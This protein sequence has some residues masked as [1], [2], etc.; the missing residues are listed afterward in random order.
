MHELEKLSGGVLL[1]ELVEFL[2]R[3]GELGVLLGLLSLR[4][5]STD[6]LIAGIGLL[7]LRLGLRGFLGLVEIAESG[8]GVFVLLLL[9]FGLVLVFAVLALLVLGF[10]LGLIAFAIL[11]FGLGVTLLTLFA[12]FTVLAFVAIL[13]LIALITV[14][15]LVFVFFFVLLGFV[16]VFLF[17]IFGWLFLGIL[18]EFFEIG[19]EFRPV[20]DMGVES[21]TSIDAIEGIVNHPDGG[22]LLSG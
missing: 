8:F 18:E 22:F 2:Q 11:G 20:G 7:G 5:L 4:L 19:A 10:G 15:F 12:L 16:F 3:D 13:T 6:L 17:L 1:F 21:F 14:L 9:L